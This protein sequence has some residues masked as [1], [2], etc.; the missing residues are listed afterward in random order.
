VKKLMLVASL[1]VVAAVVAPVASASAAKFAGHCEISGTAT[2][3]PAA[4]TPTPTTDGY[5]FSGTASCETVGKEVK[6]GTAEVEGSGTLSCE[7]A[8]ST[9]GKG[10]LTLNGEAYP[11]TLTVVGVLPGTPFIVT[12][13]SDGSVA[14]GAATFLQS[15]E[16]PASNCATTGVK[17]LQFKAQTA[18][19][20]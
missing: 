11:F 20:V 13:F 19:E 4:L 10:V 9:A 14:A 16:E 1:V 18:G 2:F 5:K 8:L 12:Q 15:T 3:A 7:A 6:T 17:K